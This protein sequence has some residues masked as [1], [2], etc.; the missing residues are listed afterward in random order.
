MKYCRECLVPDTKP[1]ISFD[2]DGVCN[3][4]QAHKLKN[5]YLNGINWSYKETEFENIVHEAAAKKA[6]FLCYAGAG[7]RR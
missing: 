5:R 2:Q 4:C 6:P 3:A 1:Y 7:K